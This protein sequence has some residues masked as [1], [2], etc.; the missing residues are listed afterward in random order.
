MRFWVVMLALGA[1]ACSFGVEP[2]ERADYVV[3]YTGQSTALDGTGSQIV[4]RAASYADKMPTLK[5]VVAGFADAQGAPEADQIQSRIRAQR[6]ADALVGDG[7]G[8][9]RI[10]LTPRRALGSDPASESR[11]VEIRL[12]R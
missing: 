5:I 9:D 12:D 6:V 10:K 3:F 2:D 4:A 8:R 1:A 7:V 11:R